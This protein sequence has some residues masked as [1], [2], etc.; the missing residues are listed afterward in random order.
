MSRHFLHVMSRPMP[1]CCSYP[2]VRLLIFDN[3]L[4]RN[5][6]C[7]SPV[8]W[9]PMEADGF[10]SMLHSVSRHL[11]HVMS[12]LMPTCCSYRCFPAKSRGSD[13][14]SLTMGV[15][16]TSS[17]I[18]N[19]MISSGGRWIVF[20]AAH[21]VTTSFARHVCTHAYLLFLSMFVEEGVRLLIFNGLLQNEVCDKTYSTICNGGR[22][23][24]FN[25]APR[26]TTSLHLMAVFMPTCCFLSLFL[27]PKLDEGGRPLIFN[28]R[29]YSY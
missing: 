29:P 23:I 9:F 11:L 17:A 27:L 10:C 28:R 8:A 2:C 12:V 19:S 13:C 3:G 16:E 26:V 25:A 20:N 21:R 14:W 1:T 15:F 18:T 24:V 22:W 4:L 6:I 5:Q 7:D